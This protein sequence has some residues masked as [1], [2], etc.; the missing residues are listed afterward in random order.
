MLTG[1]VWCIPIPNKEAETVVQAYLTNVFCP[2]G[3][4]AQILSDNGTEFKNALFEKVAKDLGCTRKVYTAPYHPQ[5]NGRIE[6]FHNFLKNCIAKHSSQR[7]DWDMVVPLACAAYNFF[8]NEHSRES[9][10]FLM[11]GRDPIVPIHQI[12]EP[13]LRYLG[14]SDC[15]LSLEELTQAYALAAYNVQKARQK[16]DAAF[17][18]TEPRQLSV[19][20]AVFIKDHTHE[21]FAPKYIDNYRIVKFH[22]PR[23]VEVVDTHGKTKTVH[24][25]DLHFVYPCDRVVRNLP[26][27]SAFGRAARHVF[28]PTNITDLKWEVTPEKVPKIVISPPGEPP[29]RTPSP[30]SV[31]VPPIPTPRYNLRPRVK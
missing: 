23:Q 28:T 1:Y 6:G 10:F 13:K 19:G 2:Y 20:D 25:S 24:I 3:G 21:V 17:K 27:E 26:D 12:L 16:N 4:S 22:S 7:R 15:L 14:D 29:S 30:S 8:P 31:K 5:S 9:P 18:K 11:F